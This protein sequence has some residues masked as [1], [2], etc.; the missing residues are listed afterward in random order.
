M[1]DTSFLDA[2]IETLAPRAEGSAEAVSF[3]GD[4]KRL[5]ELLERAETATLVDGVEQLVTFAMF[6]KTERESPLAGEAFL[7]ALAAAAIAPLQKAG[8]AALAKKLAG[9]FDAFAP[10]NAPDATV[11]ANPRAFSSMQ[12]TAAR[13]A[14]EAALKLLQVRLK[15]TPL[16][17]ALANLDIASLA[18]SPE[19]ERSHVMFKTRDGAPGV[20]SGAVAH[21]LRDAISDRFELAAAVIGRP[22]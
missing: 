13:R 6:L 16:E 15:Q 9:G 5:P 12:D 17:G 2:A 14:N 18:L 11:A 10:P 19:G 4:L 8:Q 7:K 22:I 21:A 1:A 3:G 20:E